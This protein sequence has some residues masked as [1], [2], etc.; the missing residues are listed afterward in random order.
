M[1]QPVDGSAA[2]PA[3]LQ[4]LGRTID[5]YCRAAGTQLGFVVVSRMAPHSDSRHSSSVVW[6]PYMPFC[7]EHV[8]VWQEGSYPP[9]GQA[10]RSTNSLSI[11]ISSMRKA[12]GDAI[13][14]SRTGGCKSVK[15]VNPDCSTNARWRGV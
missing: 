8:D 6:G 12:A 10:E 2:Y 1:A 11:M 13:C 7:S 14:G 15:L 5:G 9:M 4:L 3:T